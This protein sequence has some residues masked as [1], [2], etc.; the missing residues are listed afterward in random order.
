[1]SGMHSSSAESRDVSWHHFER[2]LFRFAFC[3]IVLYYA[4]FVL[5]MIP[6]TGLP[7]SWYR[8]LRDLIDGVI[9]VSLF[10]LNALQAVPHP[11]GSGDTALAYIH[12]ALIVLLA[13]IAG[14]VWTMLDRRRSHYVR[15]HGWLRVLARYTLAFALFGY[16]FAKI[17]PIQFGHLGARQLAETYGQS[18]PMALLWH[19][20]AFSTPYTVFGGCAE[21]LPAV[22]LLFRRTALLGALISFAVLLNVVVLNFC[23][24]VPV[25]LYS[26]N[27]LLLSAFLILPETRRLLRVFVLNLPA[28]SSD[29]REP[30]FRSDR[31]RRMVVILKI[32]AIAIVLAQT[33]NLAVDSYRSLAT[34]TPPPASLLTS[35]GFHWVQ[36][37]P[38]NK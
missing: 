24:D 34:Q 15:L 10:N 33:L 18:S 2:L 12:Q 26:L 32:A 25:K 8:S 30:F 4:P 9:G 14:A 13:L 16:A 20:M 31:V 35:R 6:G 37:Y 27:L 38:Y 36:E 29:L 7:L 22:L 19:F 21:L 23:Y 11:T 5:K 1:M 3:Y 17:I 28:S